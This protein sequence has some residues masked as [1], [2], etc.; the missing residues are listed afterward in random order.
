[1]TPATPVDRDCLRCQ[2]PTDGSKFC[3]DCRRVRKQARD[4]ADRERGWT[5]PVEATLDADIRLSTRRERRQ[6][7]IGR[8]K[9]EAFS[10]A[11]VVEDRLRDAG[12]P[13]GPFEGET[14]PAMPGVLGGGDA[15]SWFEDHPGWAHELGDDDRFDADTACRRDARYVRDDRWRSVWLLESIPKYWRAD[16]LGTCSRRARG[17]TGRLPARLARATFTS[18]TWSKFGSSLDT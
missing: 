2:T 4:R 17:R 15:A 11:M 16:V 8:L 1:M 5:R 7:Q 13:D 14:F 9:R 6:E 12:T 3:R 10:D 18:A